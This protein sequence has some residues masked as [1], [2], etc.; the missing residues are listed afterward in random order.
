MRKRDERDLIL[1]RLFYRDVDIY[2]VGKLAG[3]SWFDRFEAKFER[4]KYAYFSPDEKKEAH[5]RIVSEPPDDVFVAT[6]DKVFHQE[7]GY[8]EIDRFVGE[9]YY[10]D[11]STG[12]SAENRQDG[13]KTDVQKALVETNGRAYH[14]L[15]AI[16]DLHE[17]D[18]WD[19]AYGGATWVDIVA[20][21][22]ELGGSYPSP[23]DLVILKSYR[24]YYRTGSR[25]YPTHTIPEEVIPPIRGILEKWSGLRAVSG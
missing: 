2:K 20:K 21:T 7:R 4:D 11:E 5:E 9:H 24:I 12:L 1:K 10:F 22:R 6:I 23:R 19:R 13:L 3:I 15:K 14:F 18:K 17:E 8:A 16:I 25:R